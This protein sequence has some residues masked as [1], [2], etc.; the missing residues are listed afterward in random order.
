M[1]QSKEIVTFSP[2]AS[3]SVHPVTAKALR[4]SNL[5]TDRGQRAHGLV[6]EVVSFFR[7]A[8]PSRMPVCLPAESLR[9]EGSPVPL[10]LAAF[11]T[12]A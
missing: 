3:S 8:K 10:P 1:Q 6:A 12:R 5:G 2:S 7:L 11:H 4:K 9:G